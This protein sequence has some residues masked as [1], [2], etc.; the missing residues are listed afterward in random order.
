MM[1]WLFTTAKAQIAAGATLTSTPLWV[2][3][4]QNVSLVATSIAAVGG[5][6]ITIFGVIR[7]YREYRKGKE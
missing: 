7:A 1:D 6:I 2:S 5:A 3:I 4:F